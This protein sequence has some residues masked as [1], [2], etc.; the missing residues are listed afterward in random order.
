MFDTLGHVDLDLDLFHYGDLL[1]NVV[2]CAHDH[3][4]LGKFQNSV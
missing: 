1:G 4:N 3:T 2:S